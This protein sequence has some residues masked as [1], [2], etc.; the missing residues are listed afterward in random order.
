MLRAGSRREDVV[1]TARARLLLVGAIGALLLLGIL[2]PAVAGASTTQSQPGDRGSYVVQH[3]ATVVSSATNTSRSHRLVVTG[4]L[5][6]ALTL[7]GVAAQGMASRGR[8]TSR[9]RAEQFHVR[10]RGPPLLLVAH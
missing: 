1:I 6:V 7:A 10:R 2:S 3:E 8:R 9:R 4:M 5:L